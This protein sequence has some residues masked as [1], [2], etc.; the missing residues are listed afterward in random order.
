MLLI[1]IFL[2]SRK[3]YFI[4]CI[5]Y[6]P[7]LSAGSRRGFGGIG[8]RTK[9]IIYMFASVYRYI[10]TYV[11]WRNGERSS[12]E[13][14]A[15][16]VPRIRDKLRSRV[17]RANPLTLQL[18]WHSRC[19]PALSSTTYNKFFIIEKSHRRSSDGALPRRAIARRTGRCNKII[20]V[21]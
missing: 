20:S 3:K 5:L 11:I 13:T 9:K 4:Q 2:P 21:F 16:G 15:T 14:S 17:K 8:N 10:Y 19:S 1:N 6:L 18:R 7:I 12:R